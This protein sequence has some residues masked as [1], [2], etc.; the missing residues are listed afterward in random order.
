MKLSILIVNWNSKDYLKSCLISIRST[1][2]R[3]SPQ[4]VVVDAGSYD[5]CASMLAGEFPEVA[6]IQ[7]SVNLGFAKA[8]NLGFKC[9][10]GEYTLLLNPDTEL[11]SGSIETLIDVIQRR[12][13]AGIVAPR[14]LNSDGSLQTSCV[15]ALPTPWN[16]A[17]DCDMLRNLFPRW[18]IWGTS[19]AFSASEPVEVEAVSGACM[20]GK[21]EILKRVNCFSSE[22]FM[23]GEDMDLCAKIRR[24]GYKIYH[25]SKARVIHHGSGSSKIQERGLNSWRMRVAIETYMR[26]NHGSGH[27]LLYRALQAISAIIRLVIL[28]IPIV[29]FPGQQRKL[30]QLSFKKW[31]TILQ[32]AVQYSRHLHPNSSF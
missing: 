8:N 2:F 21:T 12:S 6:F 20:L 16:Q 29:A 23:Y 26:L 5:G 10:V 25:V 1:C 31:L 17:L 27:A 3:L 32:W 4:I 13:D 14:L 7:S 19:R 24:N 9:V 22:F 15:Q 28:I 30:A 18:K 11:L